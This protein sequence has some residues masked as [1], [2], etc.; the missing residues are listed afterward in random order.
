LHIKSRNLAVT[1]HAC[2]GC[3]APVVDAIDRR[4]EHAG[5]QIA[6]TRCHVSVGH[7]R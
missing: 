2:R 1:E 7:L 5:S 3:H 6:C 4:S